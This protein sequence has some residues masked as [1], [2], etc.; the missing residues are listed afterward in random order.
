MTVQT[1][2]TQLKGL[3][4]EL[5]TYQN[6]PTCN[7]ME[8]HNEQRETDRLMQFLMGLNDTYNGVRSNILMMTPLPNV[9]QAYSIVNQDEKQRQMTSGSTE[10]FSIAAA[11]QNQS[12][13]FPQNSSNDFFN[14]HCSH[15]DKNG[16]TIETCRILKYYCSYCDKRGHSDSRCRYKRNG[17][18]TGPKHNN[19]PQQQRGGNSRNS[20]HT[21]NAADTG[22]LPTPQETQ[23]STS[24]NPLDGLTREQLQQFAQTFAMMA[25]Q[26]APGNKNAFA[27]AA[28]L[29]HCPT[30]SINSAFSQPWILDSGA[31]DHITSDST[32]FTKTSPT[33]L[34]IVN[35]PN[36][37]A[38]PITHTGN[39][40]FNSDIT[41]ENVLCVPSFRL[42]LMSASKVTGSLNCCAILFPTFCVLQDLATGKMIGLGKQRGGLYYMSPISQAPISHQ[43]S[44]SSNLW[45]L[46]LGHPSPSRLKLASSLL[47]SNNVSYHNN[48]NVCP[49]AK[50]TRLPFPLSSISTHAPFDLLHCDL[51]GPH[52]IP[53]HSGARFF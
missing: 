26:N 28:G 53:T 7:Q 52:K 41:L 12:N 40:P 30:V 46:R 37:S 21:A 38:V 25:A 48:C 23:A 27:N 13:N 18:N 14:K 24:A 45:H 11:V 35:L 19:K 33:S 6:L 34:P 15:C 39:V 3:W 16:H 17:G 5:D 10:N 43:V 9:R 29:S 44:H 36:G 20:F 2:F 31:T 4:D 8:A 50:Q 1:Y 49:M 42:N 32:L 51:W 47:S 22:L